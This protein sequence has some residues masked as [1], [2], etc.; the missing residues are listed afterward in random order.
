MNTLQMRLAHDIEF[1]QADVNG[2]ERS[3]GGMQELQ[4]VFDY[5]EKLERHA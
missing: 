1:N 3:E 2:V 4:I 5:M